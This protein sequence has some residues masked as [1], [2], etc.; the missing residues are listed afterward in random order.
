MIDEKNKGKK[1]ARNSRISS[2][3]SSMLC[4]IEKYS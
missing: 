3:V 1:Q 2:V 4:E